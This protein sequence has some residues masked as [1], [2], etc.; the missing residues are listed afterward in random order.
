MPNRLITFLIYGL[1]IVFIVNL[2]RS[3]Y[4]LWSKGSLVS[5]REDVRKTLSEANAKFKEDLSEVESPEFIEREAREK[6]NLQREGEMVVVLPKRPQAVTTE[7][8]SQDPNWLR[9]WKLFF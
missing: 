8:K 4:S 6:L 5:E 9:W 2:S 1:C 7:A 3:I